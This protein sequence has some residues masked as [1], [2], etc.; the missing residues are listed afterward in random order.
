MSKTIIAVDSTCDLSKEMVEAKGFSVIPLT[1]KLTDKEGKNEKNYLDGVKVN[2]LALVQVMEREGKKASIQPVSL[3]EFSGYFQKF[4][5]E[6]NDV[7]YLGASKGIFE[8]TISNAYLA[9]GPLMTDKIKIA[10]AKTVSTGSALLALKA[11]EM[12]EYGM[13]AKAIAYNIG[14]MV[15]YVK[16]YFALEDRESLDKSGKCSIPK[17]M[18]ASDKAIIS[19]NADGVLEVISRPKVKNPTDLYDELIEKMKTEIAQADGDILISHAYNKEGVQY[20][21]D[22]LKSLGCKNITTV[23]MGAGNTAL[24]GKNSISVGF[25]KKMTN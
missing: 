22:K 2:T 23:I 21:V 4:V 5:E 18:L 6:E 11:S 12:L 1:V 16:T 10:D 17:K 8:T 9:L 13:T 15:P 7:L 3:Q 24:Y 25:I 14:L 20:V 19:V